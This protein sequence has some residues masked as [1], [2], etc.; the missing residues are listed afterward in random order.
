MIRDNRPGV[1]HLGR[2]V[3]QFINTGDVYQTLF[4]V[5]CRLQS[6]TGEGHIERADVRPKSMAIES[7]ERLVIR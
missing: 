4:K 1:Q 2:V 3:P 6:P 5:E 7:I